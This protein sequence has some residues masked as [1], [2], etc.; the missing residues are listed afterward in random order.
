MARSALALS[1][2]LANILRGDSNVRPQHKEMVQQISTLFRNF[3]AA[4]GHG[5]YNSLGCFFPDLLRNAPAP[6][7]KKTRRVTGFRIVALPT[8]N[9]VKETINNI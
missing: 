1:K 9:D 6:A 8:F 3:L 5:R 4:M 7:G 2:G